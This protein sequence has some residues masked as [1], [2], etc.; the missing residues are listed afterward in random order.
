MVTT[1]TYFS[2]EDFKKIN[3]EIINA[4]IIEK[5]WYNIKMNALI[6]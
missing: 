3:Y 2:S 6:K 5:H 4:T 1:F